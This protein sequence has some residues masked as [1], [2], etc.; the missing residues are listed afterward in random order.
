MIF[1]ETS[2]SGSYIIELEKL[3]DNR[4]FFARTFC[5]NEFK[6]QGLHL[7]FVQQSISYNEKRGTLRGMHYQIE[8]YEEIKIVSCV[9]GAIYDVIVD[10]RKESD[11]YLKWFGIELNDKNNKSLYIPKGV[12]HG[13]QTLLDK[14]IVFYQMSEVYNFESSRSILWCDSRIN[15]SW[16]IEKIIISKKDKNIFNGNK[17]EK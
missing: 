16:P 4:G 14:T 2:I 1:K 11:T 13:F 6:K 17:N 9:Q 8:P 10:L 12:A 3:K 15:I 5:K 7:D